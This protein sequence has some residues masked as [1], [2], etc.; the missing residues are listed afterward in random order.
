LF[1]LFH[2]FALT[3][4]NTSLVWVGTLICHFFTNLA[5]KVLS[6]FISCDFAIPDSFNNSWKI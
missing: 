4:T 2:L 3:E 1:Q 5:H 6:K